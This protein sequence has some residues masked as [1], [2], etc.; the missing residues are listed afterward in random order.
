MATS[1]TNDAVPIVPVSASAPRPSVVKEQ[2]SVA[3]PVNHAEKPE[4]LNG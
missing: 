1:E 2:A 4:K 3:I